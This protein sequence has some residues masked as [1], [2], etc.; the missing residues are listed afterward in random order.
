MM[1]S[2]QYRKLRQRIGSQARVARELGVSKR[3]IQRL[4]KGGVVPPRDEYAMRFIAL[5]WWTGADERTM[6]RAKRL[7]RPRPTPVEDGT[8]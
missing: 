7:L 3:T 8:R 1:N 2:V 4:E 6:E 5:D